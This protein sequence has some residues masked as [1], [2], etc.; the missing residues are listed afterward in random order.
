VAIEIS[1]L[2]PEFRNKLQELL[3]ACK[4]R[5]VT[6][7]PYFTLCTPQEQGALWKQGRTITDS[8]LKVLALEN[9]KAPFL[10]HCIRTAI[11]KETNL[12]TDM[13]PGYS[14]HQWGEAC[15]CVW[16]DFAHRVNWNPKQLQDGKNGYQIYTEEAEKLGLT[17]G[18]QFAIGVDWPHVQL[19]KEQLPTAN[20]TE[21]DAEMKRR[22]NR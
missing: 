12:I 21:I 14:W 20:I 8:E 22:Y 7:S 2:I 15:D 10:A 5:G 6:M 1:L 13:I 4:A 11:P 3:S 18:G 9:A 17:P 16:V 19:R